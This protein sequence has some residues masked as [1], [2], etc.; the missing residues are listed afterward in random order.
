MSAGTTSGVDGGELFGVNVLAAG[1]DKY[2]AFRRRVVLVLDGA[3]FGTCPG[4][5]CS[6]PF[7]WRLSSSEEDEDKEDESSKEKEI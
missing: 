1:S 7:W 3:S 2:P 4:L 5:S 6:V